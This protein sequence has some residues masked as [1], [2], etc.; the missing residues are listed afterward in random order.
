[1][2]FGWLC[3][4]ILPRVYE[5][6]GTEQNQEVVHS[7]QTAS[8]I[9]CSPF[10]S[11]QIICLY[12]RVF[13]CSTSKSHID[14]PKWWIKTDTTKNNRNSNINGG[15]M[16]DVWVIKWLSIEV[17]YSQFKHPWQNTCT[18]PNL[19]INHTYLAKP[20]P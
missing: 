5:T 20:K 14:T 8:V 12:L 17:C 4:T 2:P 16:Y 18:I 11:Q 1:M 15:D 13:L 19:N 9:V 10:S 3:T 7:L 6:H